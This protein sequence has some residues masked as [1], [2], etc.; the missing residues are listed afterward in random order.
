MNFVEPT[1]LDS[2]Q[3]PALDFPLPQQK[4]VGQL[5]TILLAEDDDDLR[6]VMEC[7]LTAMGYQ[8]IACADAQLA[9]FAFHSQSVIDVLLTDFQMPGKSGIELAR[10]LTGTHPSLPVMIITGSILS[11]ETVQEIQNRNWIYVS[12]PCH[13]PSLEA[14]LKKLLV[15]ECQGMTKA[16]ALAA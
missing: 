2:I 4:M 13:M 11:A 3:S 10:E 15:A 9:Y 8:V 12:K 6:F 1:S 7:T 5:K 14:T 16:P